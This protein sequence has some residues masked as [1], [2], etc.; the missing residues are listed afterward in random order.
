MVAATSVA[1]ESMVNVRLVYNATVI[2]GLFDSYQ[3]E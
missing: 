3:V 2:E 1:A